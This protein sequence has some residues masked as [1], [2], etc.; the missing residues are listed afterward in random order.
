MR[1][2]TS[3]Y[4]KK[5]QV[6]ESNIL[7]LLKE[8][9][10]GIKPDTWQREKW[11]CKTRHSIKNRIHQINY[12]IVQQQEKMLDKW[13]F[14]KTWAAGRHRGDNRRISVLFAGQFSLSSGVQDLMQNQDFPVERNKKKKSYLLFPQNIFHTKTSGIFL[15]ILNFWL[16]H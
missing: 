5:K 3:H 13:Y 12:T 9:R 8:K 15:V 6:K 7:H 11:Q 16:Q 10:N 4:K 14:S 2:P 1:I